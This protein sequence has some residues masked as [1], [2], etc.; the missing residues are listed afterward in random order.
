MKPFQYHEPES[1][2][3]A[4]RLLT[5]YGDRARLMAGGTDLVIQM[6]R[7]H[8]SPGH[9]ISI[10]KIEALHGI[11]ETAEG[12]TIG[13][14]TSL[15]D[16]A[17]HAR[18]QEIL[19][20]V[21]RA[22]LSVG[23]TQVRNRASIG[24]NICNGAPSADMAPGLLALGAQVAIAGVDGDRMIPVASFFTGP[25]TIL[26]GKGE[27]V[28]RLFIPRPSENLRMVYIKHG[29]RQSMDCAVVGVAICLSIDPVTRLCQDVRIALGAVA[30]TPVRA[31]ATEAL[32]AG[33]KLSELD[34]KTIE[35]L[36]RTEASPISDV[37]ASA[38]YRSEM[39]STLTT[40]AIENLRGAAREL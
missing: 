29:P 3:E 33:K 20:M 18:L 5:V 15:A 2:P 17:N 27:I 32:I 22:A 6:K 38:A 19:P 37:R 8:L 16:V 7:G 4:C 25:G 24:G 12:F 14:A 11:T 30:P 21:C 23:S 28:S 13:A 40:R 35:S 31:V 34:F 10:K 1:I 39:V 26:L 36:V 9:V